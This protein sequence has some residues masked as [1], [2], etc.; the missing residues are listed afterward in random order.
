MAVDLLAVSD[1]QISPDGSRVAFSVAPVGHV[2]TNPISAI[3]VAPSDGSTTPVCVTGRECNN[4][5]PR[6]SPDGSSIAFLSDRLK[7]GESQLHVMPTGGG[8]PL[9]L[10]EFAGGVSSLAWM[11]NRQALIASV[12]RRA[13]ERK[14]ET[15]SEIRVASERA[16][17]RGLVQVPAH[18]GACTPVGP[19]EGHIWSYAV[20]PDG[21]R[22]AAF[23]SPT[24]DLS[25]SWDNMRLSIFSI[26]SGDSPLDVSRFSGPPDCA[27]WSA[28][29]H[30]LTFLANKLPEARH[31]RAW[32]VDAQTG[33]LSALDER[34]M[35]QNWIGFDGSSLVVLSVESQRTRLDVAD[36][37][38][39]AWEQIEL[40]DELAERWIRGVSL[41]ADGRTMALLAEPE[42]APAD[43]WTTTNGGSVTRVTQ[44]NPQLAN[45]ALSNLEPLSWQSTDGTSIDGWL[46]RPPGTEDGG[47]LPLV[48]YVHGGPSWQWGNWFHGTWHD[49]AH[50]LA[51]RGFAVFLPNPR[52]STG[53][54]GDFTGVNDNDLGGLDFD[55]I[56]TGVDHLIERGIA[57]PNRLGIGGWSYGGFIVAWAVGKTNRFKAAVAGAAVTN[58]VSK[59]GTTDIR[60]MNEANFPGQLHEEPDALWERSPVR[61][62]KDMKTPTLIVH[63]EADP[64]VPVT[65]GLELY[66]GLK[67]MGVDT[68]FV[69]YPRQKHAFHERA[70]QLDLLQRVCD[71]Y[72]KHLI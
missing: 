69:T 22:I 10:T 33:E 64:R 16:R 71:W 47:N 54:G 63:G 70:S 25:D 45:V 51:A 8:Q 59:I 29:G 37:A 23:M 72:E 49:W 34:G 66:L 36:A 13:L 20:S 53:R 52:G 15:G 9:R 11:P 39:K 2:E 28:D 17:P 48:V 60:R 1:V 43:V 62:L 65:Q 31:G 67:A 50:V 44:M 14:S 58:W 32:V 40:P 35:T 24:E 7:R 3:F 4:S 61:Y 5:S 19:S 56:M 38:G 55:D 6:W 26:Q 42:T 27:A 21:A 57:D 12:S 30:Y 68:E 46:L 18:G 41:S